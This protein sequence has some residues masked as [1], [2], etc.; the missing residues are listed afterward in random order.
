MAGPGAPW[1]PGYLDPVDRPAI[2][3][4]MLANLRAIY[5]RSDRDRLAALGWCALRCAHARTPRPSDRRELVRLMAPRC[6]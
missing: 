2:V 5:Q 3:A 1:D 4:R 6:N